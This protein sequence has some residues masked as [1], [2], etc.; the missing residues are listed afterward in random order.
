MNSVFS[1]FQQSLHSLPVDVSLQQ[2]T[3]LDGIE[4]SFQTFWTTVARVRPSVSEPQR[5]RIRI[6]P[7][8]E[9]SEERRKD[10]HAVLSQGKPS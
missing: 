4:T 2:P 9:P 5:P 1:R 3:P 7:A 6:E 8:A 10:V